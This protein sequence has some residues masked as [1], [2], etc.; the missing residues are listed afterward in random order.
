MNQLLS[1]AQQP[2]RPAPEQGSIE[3]DSRAGGRVTSET[4]LI[5]IVDDDRLIRRSLERLLKSAGLKAKSFDSAE[6]YLDEGD[7]NGICCIILDIGLPGMSGFE[8]NGRLAAEPNRLPVVFI[9][10]HDEPEV[11]DKATQAGAVAFLRKP[12][13]DD[14]LLNAVQTG[15]ELLKNR[16]Q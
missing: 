6:E 14:A 8:L 9:S 12:F 5:A 13:E 16:G 4:G 11:E 7:H 10:A 2:A 1:T 3:S 15:M